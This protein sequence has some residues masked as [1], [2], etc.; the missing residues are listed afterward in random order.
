MSEETFADVGNIRSK[1]MA[2]IKSKDATP[3]IDVRRMVC[4]LGVGYR[5][6]R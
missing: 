3:E 2:A 4:S 6:H 5:L 1:N